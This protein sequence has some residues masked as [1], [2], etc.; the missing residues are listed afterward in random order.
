MLELFKT[1]STLEPHTKILDIKKAVEIFRESQR[2]G[3]TLGVTTGIFDLMHAGH[4][5]MLA[6]AKS[7]C[8]FLVVLLNDQKS[9]TELR[10]EGRPIMRECDRAAVVASDPNVDAV[11]LFSGLTAEP[12]LEKLAPDHLIKGGD[13]QGVHIP[14]QQYARNVVFTTVMENIHTTDIIQ[15]A[16]GG[17]V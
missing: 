12:E 10:G 15:Q 4:R 7:K 8:D 17:K 5:H 2:D 13:W 16:A 9:A 11:V 14:G 3:L 1:Y 6:E